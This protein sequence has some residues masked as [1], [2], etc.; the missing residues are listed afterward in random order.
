VI[1]VLAAAL[2]LAA[3]A[4]AKEKL[5]T[6]SKEYLEVGASMKLNA[7]AYD[8]MVEVKQGFWAWCKSGYNPTTDSELTLGTVVNAATSPLLNAEA[9]SQ[10][11]IIAQRAITHFFRDAKVPVRESGGKHRMDV[12]IVRDDLQPVQGKIYCVYGAEIKIVDETGAVLFRGMLRI[13]DVSWQAAP[14]KWAKDFAALL[15][16]FETKFTKGFGVDPDTATKDSPPAPP[17]S[18]GGPGSGPAI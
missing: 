9:L 15:G 16:K 4:T 8:K 3:S 12:V 7:G 2:V 13:W 5:F 17:A 1:A 11:V 10:Q 6:D 18:G 14:N